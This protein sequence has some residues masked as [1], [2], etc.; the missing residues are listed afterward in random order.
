MPDRSLHQ[1]AGETRLR[2]ADNYVII[3]IVLVCVL[4]ALVLLGAGMFGS[5]G[6]SI[7]QPSTQSPVATQPNNQPPATSETP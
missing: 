5:D 3:G 2:S 6:K 4:M 7:T 1:D